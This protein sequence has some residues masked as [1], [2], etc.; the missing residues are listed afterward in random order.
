MT[1][2]YE[3]RRTI[4]DGKVA[5]EF[6]LDPSEFVTR[7]QQSF[8]VM[9]SRISYFPLI[10]AKPLQF[11]EHNVDDIDEIDM[12]N[13]WLESNGKPL[14]WHC[15]IGVLYDIHVSDSSLPWVVTLRLKGKFPDELVRCG[16]NHAMKH[17]FLQTVKEADQLKHK[18]TVM[19]AMKS[20]EH[21]QLFQSIVNDKFDDFWTVNKKLMEVSDPKMNT[22][23]M[24]FYYGLEPFRQILVPV[25]NSSETE[26]NVLS[27]VLKKV[28]PEFETANNLAVISHG[29]LVPLDSPILWL[30]KNF[31]YPDNFVHLVVK[32]NV[33]RE[34]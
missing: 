22:V 5:V 9:L 27:T 18:G 33:E 2:D 8:F 23:P 30:C 10:L 26:T 20:D 25:E 15:P 12:N 32:D 31:S 29:I 4:W 17:Y 3:V 16:S 14:K 34:F 13:I 21:E 1:D 19:A 7:A 6:V 28:F 24:R 11:F